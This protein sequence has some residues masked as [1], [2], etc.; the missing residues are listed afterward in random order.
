MKTKLYRPKV[1]DLF[2]M[3]LLVPLLL[4][5]AGTAQGLDVTA[6][7][8][9]QLREK[10]EKKI[11]KLVLPRLTGEATIDAV[12][13]EPFWQYAAIQEI[14]YESFPTLMA[15]APVKTVVRI[16]RLQDYLLLSFVCEDPDPDKIQAPWKD[17]DGIDMDDYTFQQATEHVAECA[18]ETL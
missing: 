18:K 14:E 16:A 10:L 12:L 11:N 5:S 15:P 13:D 4:I 17:R 2:R 9:E 7:S 8:E 1:P 6:M 3:F